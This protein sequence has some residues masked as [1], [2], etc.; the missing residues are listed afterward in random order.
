MPPRTAPKCRRR[1][2]T[3]HIDQLVE[4]NLCHGH[5][6]GPWDIATRHEFAREWRRWG[7]EITRRWVEAFPGSRPMAAYIVGEIP[8]PVFEPEH[9][10]HRP[11][12]LRPI[13]GIEVV[14]DDTTFHMGERELRHLVALGIVG[15]R[16]ERLA[17]AR[18]DGP[19]PT[20][21]GRYRSI[22]RDRPEPASARRI[23]D[24][25]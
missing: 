7:A 15:K 17:L 5:G 22:Y 20:Y 19:D 23:V 12:P 4:F 13:E 21:H 6:F 11:R 2:T 8:P 3:D 1:G 25:D 24:D 16:E 10:E 18:L 14:I 9:D